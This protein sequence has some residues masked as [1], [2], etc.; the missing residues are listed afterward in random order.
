MKKHAYLIMAHNNFYILEKLLKLL[1]DE[2]NDIYIHIDKK[3]NNFDFN[4]FKNICVRSNIK[5]IKRI[6]V[7]WGGYSQVKCE[8]NLLKQAIKNNYEYYHLL[9]GSDLPI[10]TQ[11]YIHDFFEKNQGIEFIR[12]MDTGWNY[13][14]VSNIH[15]FRNYCKSDKKILELLYNYTNSVITKF[16]NRK[17][18]DYTKKFNYVFKKG[19]QWFSI[20]NELAHYICKSENK[21]KKMF[22]YAACPDE[23]FI[24][25]IAYNSKFKQNISYYTCKREIDWDR[26]KPYV[27]RL[28]DYDLL[29]DSENLFARKFDVGI[30]VNII[31]KIYNTIRSEENGFNK[32]NSSSI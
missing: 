30:D 6:K 31:D 5:F 23:H 26:G 29:I 11:D 18:Y 27:Y 25:T 20:T 32:Y 12:Y 4:Y 9:S 24:H 28:E 22:R 13:E 17:C 1:D 7:Y 3:V 14:R 10:K 19:D 16:I 8:L 2:R 15:L 21:I